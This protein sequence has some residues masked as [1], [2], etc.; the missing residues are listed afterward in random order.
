[1]QVESGMIPWVE[2][3]RCVCGHSPPLH[4][5]HAPVKL[6]PSPA[7][8]AFFWNGWC[9]SISG[10]MLVGIVEEKGSLPH[11][12]L[13]GTRLLTFWFWSDKA[14]C[15]VHLFLSLF[16][17]VIMFSAVMIVVYPAVEMLYFEA[18][19]PMG[20]SCFCYFFPFFLPCV[21]QT[22]QKRILFEEQKTGS[23]PFWGVNASC[24]E[25]TYIIGN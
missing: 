10:R 17:S 1:M 8:C 15:S 9:I 7:P 11:L 25:I 6:L 21:K 20:K 19:F 22:K 3:Q 5:D 2:R 14:A 23:K 18:N 4:D 24:I 16:L 13:G 12:I